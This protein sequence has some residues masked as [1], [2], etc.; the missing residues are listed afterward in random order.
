MT[1]RQKLVA[2]LRMHEGVRS[3][4][5]MD[6][7]G[8][9]TIGVG[10]NLSDVGLSDDEI[11]VLLDDDI[12]EVIRDLTTFPWFPDLDPVR[13]RVLCD[14]RFNLGPVRLR[15]FKA[16][17]RYMSEADHP[18][19]ARALQ[20]SLWY[21]QVGTRGPRLVTMLRTGDDYRD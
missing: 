17:L 2:Q 6:S 12:N 1:D 19:A 4:P 8:K 5:Y 18:A 20:A 14:L 13:Q 3:K 15:G 11:Q 10:R 21:T 16:M 7:V 9:I